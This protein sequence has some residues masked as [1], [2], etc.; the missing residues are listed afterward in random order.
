MR[1]VEKIEMLEAQ[2]E[3]LKEKYCDE[4][5]EYFCEYC[6]ARIDEIEEC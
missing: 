1:V 3:R 6:W 5:Q 2:I 4:C